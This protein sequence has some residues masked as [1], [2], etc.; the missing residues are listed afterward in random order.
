M[1]NEPPTEGTPTP[2]GE[3]LVEADLPTTSTTPNPKPPT[4]ASPP[5]AEPSALE[6]FDDRLRQAEE[7]LDADIEAYARD[8]FESTVRAIREEYGPD[9]DAE[10]LARSDLGLPDPEA[11]PAL[12]PPTYDGL[13]DTP[14]PQPLEDN[15][16]RQAIETEISSESRALSAEADRELLEDTK[17][18][19]ALATSISPGARALQALVVGAILALGGIAG[20]ALVFGPFSGDDSAAT[21][22]PAAAVA[23]TTAPTEAPS[24]TTAPT[25]APT[26][27]PS[28]T[29]ASA[30]GP[31]EGYTTCQIHPEED[32]PYCRPYYAPTTSQN[33][34]WPVRRY[35]ERTVTFR[36]P[37]PTDPDLPIE[38][39]LVISGP[40]GPTIEQVLSAGPGE[41]L[42]CVRTV[43]GTPT[44]DGPNDTC[45]LIT[46]PD[47]IYMQ[48]DLSAY[49]EGPLA[50]EWFAQEIEPGDVLRGDYSNIYPDA[51]LPAP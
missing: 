49:G 24:A 18:R 8:R 10:A 50:I 27:A 9:V 32:A 13:L 6:I 25:E 19:P 16:V 48:A 51:S 22:L 23:A 39:K 20:W 46:A 12:P 21:S 41:P 43:G 37:V 35:F 28:A 26:A 15:R 5:D 42:S 45:G 34:L 14:P 7:N 11:E 3:E 40:A 29:A 44:A 1:T 36:A 2:N 4:P 33:T 17:V 38:Y 30:S 31:P 47:T